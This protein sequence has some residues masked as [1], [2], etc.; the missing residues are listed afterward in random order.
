[1][2]EKATTYML[3]QVVDIMDNN[4]SAFPV[5]HTNDTPDAFCVQRQRIM[6]DGDSDSHDMDYGYQS[7]GEYKY[8]S[9]EIAIAESCGLSP[10]ELWR[11]NDSPQTSANEDSD[12]LGPPPSTS[13]DESMPE[14][15]QATF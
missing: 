15:V 5:G 4:I 13:T 2:D 12:S 11:A 9:E 14:L 10:N 8:D 7:D 3:N 1:M 6:S